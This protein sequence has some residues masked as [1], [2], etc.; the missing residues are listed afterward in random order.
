MA[1]QFGSG[2]MTTGALNRQLYSR[3]KATFDR[4]LIKNAGEARDSVRKLN[5]QTG[6]YEEVVQHGGEYYAVCCPLCNDTRFRCSIN[7]LYGVDD[8][9]GRPRNRLVHCFNAG[10]PLERGDREA[11]DKME[12]WILGRRLASLRKA[13][14]QEGVKVDYTAIRSTW[15]GVVH[16]VD[17]LPSDHHAVRYLRDTRQFNIKTLGTFYNVHWCESSSRALCVDRL[18]IPLYH[19]RKMVGWQ[20]RHIGDDVD[21]AKSPF[22]KYYTAPGTP[23]RAFLYNLGNAKNYETGVI[24]EGVTDVWAVG[25]MAVC[26]LGAAMT[27]P[28][29]EMF[30]RAFRDHSGV[31]LYDPDAEEKKGKSLLNLPAEFASLRHGFCKVV[32]PGED[33]PGKYANRRSLLRRLVTEEAAKQGVLVSWRR[34]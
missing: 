8:D 23:R 17:R 4:V 3:L 22:P 20:S 31:L 12:D 33:D 5:L 16:R 25:P 34:R 18:I 27:R 2:S 24:V 15:P 6:K 11:Y 1:V 26:T 30:R 7:H 32:L 28:Q 14:I 29:Q 13:H 9:W 10:C 21:W 19:N